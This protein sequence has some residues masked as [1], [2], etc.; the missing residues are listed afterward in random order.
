M[1]FS[2][3][4][5][6]FLYG[7][8]REKSY[9]SGLL[10][11]VKLN[12]PVVSVGNVQFGGS[13]KTPFVM[14]LLEHFSG[15]KIAVV[16]QS[17][18]ADLANPEKVDLTA[19]DF[20]KKYGDE[21]ALIKSKFPNVDVWCGPVKWKTAVRAD[22]SQKYD[23]IIL[24]DGF[25]HHKLVRDIDI[26]LVDGSRKFSTYQLP[27]NGR[28]REPLSALERSDLVLFTK[29]RT[30]N[31]NQSLFNV[32]EKTGVDMALVNYEADKSEIKP[33]SSYLLFAGIG[34]FDFF[35]KNAL[36]NNIEVSQFRQFENHCEYSEEKQINLLNDL[37]KYNLRGLTTTKD[38]IKFTNSALINRTDCLRIKIEMNPQSKSLLEAHLGKIRRE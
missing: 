36:D 15:K 23:V 2:F 16:S 13:G 31:E 9:S 5:P 8:L 28:L 7:R 20:F 3:L 38:R 11:K 1:A 4:N 27:P 10:K 6:I 19:P 30:F 25:T 22:Q 33:N 14:Y 21:P 26:V 32:I 37:E 17:Y 18:R 12:A 35:K 24:D 34:N 29:I